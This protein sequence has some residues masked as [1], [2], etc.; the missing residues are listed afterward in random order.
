MSLPAHAASVVNCSPVTCIPSP[1]SPANR[2][3]ARVSVR[4]GFWA[5]PV[6]IAVS[7][8]GFVSSALVE[9]LASVHF[10][11]AL[12]DVPGPQVQDGLREEV[13]HPFDE[14]AHRDDT[15][16]PPLGVHER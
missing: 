13:R 4:R 1:E 14:V 9:P 12:D 3:T 6:G 15:D 7:L 8:I 10:G 5:T 2:M 16:G 11:G